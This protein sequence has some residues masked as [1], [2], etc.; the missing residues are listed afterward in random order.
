MFTIDNTEGFSASQLVLLNAALDKLIAAGWEEKSASDHIIN[1]WLVSGN[2]VESLT[3]PE[4]PG[5]R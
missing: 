2:T 4:I 1:N 5:P 3:G